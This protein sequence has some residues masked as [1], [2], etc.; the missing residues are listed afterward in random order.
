MGSILSYLILQS[1]L[2]SFQ[3]QITQLETYND[4]LQSQ[5]DS[6][7]TSINVLEESVHS[8]SLEAKASEMRNAIESDLSNLITIGEIV[9]ALPEVRS[10]VWETMRATLATYE[11]RLVSG[12]FIWFC[13]PNGTYYTTTQGLINRTLSDRPYFPVA[14]GGNVSVGTTVYSRSSGLAVHVT[15]IPVFNGTSVVGILGISTPLHE[16]AESIAARLGIDLPDFFFVLSE[17]GWIQMHPQGEMILTA[18]LVTG[19]GMDAAVPYASLTEFL[20]E[21]LAAKEGTGIYEYGD[22]AGTCGYTTITS[23]HWVVFYVEA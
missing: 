10:A 8:L 1:N 9:A 21:A 13:Y 4:D 14:I 19:E 12:S 15:A 22:V 5:V 7:Q 17:D 6:L 18:N 2:Q 23:L 20:E 16:W 3:T 11:S